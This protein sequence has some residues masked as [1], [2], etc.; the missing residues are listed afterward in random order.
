MST[1]LAAPAR[2]LR[3]GGVDG[4][5]FTGLFVTLASSGVVMA[6]PAPHDGLLVLLMGGCVV[7][8]LNVDRR[9]GWLAVLVA[10]TVAGDMVGSAMANDMALSV[11]HAFVTLYLSASA[12]FFALIAAAAPRRTLACAVPALA[13]AGVVTG[14]AG[15]AGFLEL[16][17]AAGELFTEYGRAKG[18]FKDPNVLAPFLILPFMF[19]FHALMTRPLARTLP[20]LPVLAVLVLAI[21]LSFSRGAWVH[22]AVSVATYLALFFLTAPSAALR[23]RAVL[24]VGAAGMAALVGL[25]AL[26]S[27]GDVGSL[28]AER[29]SLSQSYDTGATGR[30]AGQRLAL[31]LATENPL[32]LGAGDFANLHG[33]EVHNVYLNAFMNGGWIYG[34]AYLALVAATLVAGLNAALR[35]SPL[36][37]PA[38]ALAAVFVGLAFEGLVVD[39]D[40]WR[41]FYLLVG[42]VW[43][44]SV[45]SRGPRPGDAVGLTRQ[46]GGTGR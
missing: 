10:L 1:T 25:G 36:Q 23:L 29:A 14:L 18:A 5:L 19:G 3:I 30:F 43:G 37:G 11:K 6:E 45:A 7:A 28:F 15:I 8:G 35:H 4:L 21:F 2:L 34:F 22:L 17:P 33:E 24:V 39:T 9:L 12:V 40:H 41:H 16:H 46:R 32:G 26:A 42:L 44:V 38:M 13:I 27:S 20:W 31:M